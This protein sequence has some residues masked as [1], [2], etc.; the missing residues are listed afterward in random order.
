MDELG[1]KRCVIQIRSL[2]LPEAQRTKNLTQVD[3]IKLSVVNSVGKTIKLFTH[4]YLETRKRVIGIRWRLIRIYSV[5][6]QVFFIKNRI[7][8][9]R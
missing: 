4:S 2:E 7:R 3:F 5:C 6:L 1:A 8:A 9:T